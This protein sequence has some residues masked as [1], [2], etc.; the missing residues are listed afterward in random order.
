MLRTLFCQYLNNCMR[1]RL[2][3]ATTIISFIIFLPAFLFAQSFNEDS[4]FIIN[5]YTKIERMIPMRDGV[6]L[7]TAF[8][9]PKDNAE[10]YPF[11][12]ERTPYSCS[13]YGEN[14]LRWWG[15]GPD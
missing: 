14:K 10:K 4:V 2:F 3:C 9:I 13:P 7:F 1:L 5:N 15:L 12:M 11:L 6:R 8:Y